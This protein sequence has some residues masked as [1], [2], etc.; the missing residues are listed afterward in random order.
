VSV[1]LTRETPVLDYQNQQHA[2]LPLVALSYAANFAGRSMVDM[3]DKVLAMVTSGQGDFSTQTAELHAISS[4]LKGWL[5][6]RVNDGIEQCRRLCGGHGFLQSSNLSHL[7]AETVGSVTYEGTADVLVQ[8][9]AR[10]LLKGLTSIVN[11]QQEGSVAFLSRS[12]FYSNPKL[13]CSA[14]SPADFGNFT[15]LVE[16]FEVRAARSVLKLAH[17]IKASGN[18]ANACM[19]LITS[20]ST[21]HAELLLLQSFISG[22]ASLPVGNTKSAVAQLSQLFGAWLLVD[23]LGDFRH[24]DYVSS[25]QAD[26][27]HRQLAN[28]LPLVRRH[29][30]RL[31]DAWDFS[32]FELNSTLGRFDGDI[33]RALVDHAKREPLN[34]SP[35]PVGYDKYL[36]P[37]TRSSL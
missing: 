19:T 20:A 9:H 34:I 29:A 23:G 30:V 24:N 7:F 1:A 5:A 28:L 12:D 37:L 3:H 32:D 11:P 27:A 33:Y 17:A 13:R 36:R 26:M 35:V 31:T 14:R 4:G 10:Y 6:D 15:V 22:V 21:H 18:K 8:Q 2:L 25:E 16:A